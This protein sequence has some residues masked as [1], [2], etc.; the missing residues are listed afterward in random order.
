M[1]KRFL[2]IVA[3]LI[4]ITTFAQRKPVFIVTDSLEVFGASMPSGHLIYDKASLRLW[5]LTAK[6]LATDSLASTTRD[7]VADGS[8][9]AATLET[10][11]TAGNT[12]GAN[13]V[14]MKLREIKF[15]STDLVSM[16][17]DGAGD[18]TLTNNS[19]APSNIGFKTQSGT[20]VGSF[21]LGLSLVTLEQ[22]GI[23]DGGKIFLDFAS[24]NPSLT[25][26]SD[27]ASGGFENKLISVT[28]TA[29]R[30]TTLQD[31]S[32]T[33]SF[34]SQLLENTDI[35][36]P[37]ARTITTAGFGFNV[38]GGQSTFKGIN[39]LSSTSP[40]LAENSSGS[41]ILKLFDDQT[42]IIGGTYGSA[43]DNRTTLLI[44]GNASNSQT[45]AIGFHIKGN[46][47]NGTTSDIVRIEQ[48]S[49]GG[50][51]KTENSLLKVIGG[52][53]LSGIQTGIQ[54]SQHPYVSIGTD[55]TNLIQ[56][57][58]DHIY[59]D[60]VSPSSGT[61]TGQF[62]NTIARTFGGLTTKKGVI[63]NS[64]GTWSDSGAGNSTNTGLE[65]TVSGGDF[66]YAGIFS[67]GQIGVGTT[68]PHASAL[69]Q[70]SSTTQGFLFM[71]MTSG[72]RDAIVSPE[73]G[74]TLYDNTNDDLN[75]YNGTAWRRLLNVAASTLDSGGVA[76]AD[77]TGSSLVTDTAN[78]F[79]DNTN[80]RL[81]ITNTN[82][83]YPLD[84]TGDINSTGVFRSGGTAG[85]SATY[86]FGGGGMGDIATMTFTGGILTAVTTVP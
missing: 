61:V 1:K 41:D 82:P 84:V 66:N 23:L 58:V 8:T 27:N 34:T 10:V 68:T 22:T 4:C 25:L 32:G 75:Y 64:T 11:L 81:G 5:A 9:G 85:L 36:L 51:P 49:A 56:L 72:Q 77:M 79:W 48:T 70:F 38:S 24:T 57:K 6:A 33:L 31:A 2:F 20:T 37:A 13:D 7:L 47:D 30:T 3:L 43:R 50:S 12:P 29:D 83:A 16:I 80:N 42:A 18:W 73:N 52:F 45:N 54:I 55:V 40:F 17:E 53:S 46:I 74:L 60:N 71:D 65:V 76:F 39:D 44:N 67:G 14:L 78:I 26:E 69:A 19:G 86:T 28:P 35:T 63:I 62:N 15:G 21:G 59:R